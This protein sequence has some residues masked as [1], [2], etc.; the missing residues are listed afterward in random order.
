[1][2]RLRTSS[3]KKGQKMNCL[4]LFSGTESFSKVARK[5]GYKTFTVD[6]DAQ[7]KPDLCIDILNLDVQ[8][9]KK[10]LSRKGIKKINILWASPPCTTFSVAS[11]YRYW[12]NGK[13]KNSKTY[14]GL[15]IAKKTLEI[16]EEL[17]PDYWFIE[18]PRAMLRKQYF[19]SDKHRKTVTYCQ[20]GFKIQKPTDIWTNCSEWIPRKPCR[21][22]DSCHE[23]A[24]RGQDQGT[25]AQER[26]PIKRAIIPPDLFKEIF[27]AIEGKSKVKQEVLKCIF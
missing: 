21:P 11:L 18:N 7:H 10:E 23:S 15:A 27:D 22:G 3:I 12:Y 25:Q 5:R 8:E 2:P 1:M 24:S 16:I 17:K 14:L 26:D 19:L 20:Y 4:E 9:L 13:P 6:N